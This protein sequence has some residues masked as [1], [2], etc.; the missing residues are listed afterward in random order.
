MSLVQQV[1]DKSEWP[2]QTALQLAKARLKQ[3]A[4]SKRQQRELGK[5]LL[6]FTNYTYPQYV[7][8]PFHELVA[9]V[10]SAIVDS[11]EAQR[12]MI[13]A[14]PQHG[15]S[16]L[17]GIRLPAYWLGKRPDDPVIITS[18]GAGLALRNSRMARDIV[19]GE[20]FRLIFPNAKLDRANR[21]S[22]QWGLE[23]HRGGVVAAGVGGPITGHGGMLGIVDDPHKDWAE[24]QSSTQRQAVW[25]WWRGTFLTRIWEGGSV[26]VGMTR[27]H[28]DDLAGRLLDSEGEKWEVLRLP[29]LCESQEQRDV[30]NARMGLPAGLPDAL[31]REEY[32]PL[33]PRR[34]SADALAVLKASVGSM[35]WSAEYQAYPVAAE[36]NRIKRDWFK[37]FVDNVPV[38]AKLIRYWDKAGTEGAG[39]R[40]AG[41]LLAFTKAR[42][43]IIVDVVKGQ[44]SAGHRETIIRQTA[45]LDRTK[46]GSRVAIWQEQ[47]PG[48]G[49]KD[50]ADESVRNLHGF[51]VFIDR[52]TG[53]KDVRLE[54]LAAQLE[55]E[56]V[57]LVRGTWN[58]DFIEEACSVP[59]GNFRDQ[60]DAAA[61]AY[62]KLAANPFG[63]IMDFYRK[64]AERLKKAALEAAAQ[65]AH[66]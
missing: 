33:A 30:V 38:D 52:V 42:R 43:V 7:A 36:G 17:F 5:S 8:D 3:I 15:K 55:A 31:G 65:S 40:T 53:S 4:E 50:S 39:A 63:A 27:W 13:F 26:V 10:L 45:E 66:V 56:N 58:F 22:Q 61:G 37:T 35:V 25:D 6:D 16:E 32:Q 59:N 64:R 29:A 11:P 12:V 48:S 18:Y 54:P 46:Y 62:N 34:F 20:R 57:D 28:E 21:G 19:D 49:G 23:G 60:T 14:P 24:A 47:E 51:P 44:W 2:E 1:V 41:V 9:G